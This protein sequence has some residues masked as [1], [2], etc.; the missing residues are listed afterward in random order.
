MIT[1][2]FWSAYLTKESISQAPNLK[3]ILTADIGSDHIDLFVAATR[4]I[5]VVEDTCIAY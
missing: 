1:T 5:V 4:K 3:L 2:P